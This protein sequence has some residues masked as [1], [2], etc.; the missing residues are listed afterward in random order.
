M[1]NAYI[2]H[3]VT[4]VP[5]YDVHEK[6][7]QHI[8]ASL[9]ETTQGKL[10]RRMS[11]RSG[12][13]HRYS[14]IEP[15]GTD[16]RLDER[17]FFYPGAFP[18]T[19]ER[20]R[21]YQENA[22][23]LAKRACDQLPFAELQKVTHIVVTS[24]TGFYAPGLDFDIVKHYGL[25][26]SVER[27][28]V[29]FMGCSA[30]INGLKLARHI[31]KSERGAQVLMLNAELCTLHL[32]DT[33]KM[34]ELLS[35]LLFADG[36]AA[37]LVSAQ[38]VGLEIEHFH[39]T[40]LPETHQQLTWQIGQSGFNMV[41]SGQVPSS[42]AQHL[43]LHMPAILQGSEAEAMKF[44]AVHPGGRSIVDAVESSLELPS[45]A[46]EYSRKILHDFGNMSSATIMF[47]LKE[48]MNSGATGRGCAL[49]FGPGITAE[50]ML[51][52]LS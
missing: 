44:W 16:Q 41:L 36:C 5:D 12:I 24:C 47:V 23:D 52:Q 11:K 34:E 33:Q 31:V 26:P 49:A 27:T 15:G 48:I 30:A 42:V 19:A 45:D 6:Y 25:N 4:A 14:F 21:L 9:G 10:F 2:N 29:G 3:I 18:T 13:G 22:W 20:M 38:P 35:F 43:P 1:P 32:Q 39:S 50:S 37:S 51:F 28:V 40:L 7:V 8:S 17:Q 46:L